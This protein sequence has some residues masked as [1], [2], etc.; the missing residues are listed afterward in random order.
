MYA[1]FFVL[2]RNQLLV[3]FSFFCLFTYSQETKK[4]IT[5]KTFFNEDIISDVHIINKNSNKGSVTNDFGLFE[6]S[7]L[8]GDVLE[9]SHINLITKEITI[10]KEILAQEILKIHF[11]GKTYV[12]EE[13]TVEKTRS[14][15]FLDSELMPPPKVNAKTLNLPYTNTIAIKDYTVVKIRSGG[16][17]NLDNLMNALNG[18]NRR[19]KLLKKITYKDKILSKIRKQ[20]TDDF[21][22]TDLNI[23]KENITPFLNYCFKKNIINFYNKNENLKITKILIQESRTFPQDKIEISLLEKN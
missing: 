4:I 17:V 18:N 12:L 22:I 5:G 14:I 21:F 20:F 19:R 11:E 9:F 16:V 13:I 3:Y 23:K 8:I 2:M 6:I 7:V 1:L 15:L 10:T